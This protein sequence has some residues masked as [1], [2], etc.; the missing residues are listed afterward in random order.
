MIKRNRYPNR[1]PQRRLSGK[2]G[3]QV[4]ATWP[5]VPECGRNPHEWEIKQNL[6]GKFCKHCGIQWLPGRPEPVVNPQLEMR[7]P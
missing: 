2:K 4:P 3:V 5:Q 6:T 1:R 7:E